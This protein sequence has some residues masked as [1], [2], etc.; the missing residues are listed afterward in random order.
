MHICSNHPDRYHKMQTYAHIHSRS[1]HDLI[2]R[3]YILIRQNIPYTISPMINIDPNPITR[4]S[5]KILRNFFCALAYS[6]FSCSVIFEYSSRCRRYISSLLCLSSSFSTCC[7]MYFCV[8][9]SNFLSSI[10]V[11]LS[12]FSCRCNRTTAFERLPS[13]MFLSYGYSLHFRRDCKT[14]P[15]A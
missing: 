3:L 12:V 14:P 8:S 15:A 10:R 7:L 11:Y 13:N 5:S 1:S 4:T 9:L 2:C 6:S